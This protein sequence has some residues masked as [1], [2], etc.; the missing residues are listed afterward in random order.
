MTA[1]STYGVALRVPP[2]MSAVCG[3]TLTSFQGSEV[4]KC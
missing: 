4:A 1:D 2:T 3:Y